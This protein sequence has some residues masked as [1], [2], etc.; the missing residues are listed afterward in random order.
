MPT[1]DIDVVVSNSATQYYLL[2]TQDPN[3]AARLQSATFDSSNLVVQN[4][5]DS[6]QETVKG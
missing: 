3:V 1:E 5:T 4:A 2:D 6:N